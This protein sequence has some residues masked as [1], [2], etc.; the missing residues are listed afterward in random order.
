MYPLALI[1]VAMGTGRLLQRIYSIFRR[2]FRCNQMRSPPVCARGGKGVMGFSRGG[3]TRV[4]N[5]PQWINSGEMRV[6]VM[7]VTQ[8]MPFY[9]FNFFWRVFSA[10]FARGWKLADGLFQPLLRRLWGDLFTGGFRNR[11]SWKITFYKQVNGSREIPTTI[12]P[13]N[14][15]VTLFL[16]ILNE[17]KKLIRCRLSF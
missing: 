9:L 7:F 2:F 14:F 15:S 11:V 4:L 16:Q 5:Y 1:S 12:F 6:V 17:T 13:S 10:F 8:V 3:D